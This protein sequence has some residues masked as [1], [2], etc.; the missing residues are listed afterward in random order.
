MKVKANGIAIYY[1]I[2]GPDNAPCLVFSNSL[3]TTLGMWNEQ[4]AALKDK[5]RILRYD[6]RGHGQTEAPAGRYPFDTLLAD[7]LGLLDALAIKKAHFAGLSH[8][9]R[10]RAWTC[11]KASGSVRSHHRLRLAVPVDAAKQPAMGRAHS[12]R[13]GQGHGGPGRADH[14][15]LVSA[16]DRRQESALSR[17]GARHDPRHAGERLHRLRRGACRPRLCVGRRQCDAAGPVHGRREGRRHARRHAQ[18]QRKAARLAFRRTAAAPAISR[19]WTGRR[20]SPAPFAISS[21][22]RQTK[23]AGA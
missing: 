17:Q 9:R 6:Q 16:R 3:A 8:G 10:H 2:E 12:R 7:A 21:A 22:E 19:T 5:F 11:R 1:Q 4:A 13:Q 20:S 15:A 23:R 18:A 14:C